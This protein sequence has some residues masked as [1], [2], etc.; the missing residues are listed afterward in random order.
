MGALA[1]LQLKKAYHKPED[2]IGKAFYLP[3]LA[4]ALNYDRAVGYFSSA[5][6]ALAWPSLR[7]FVDHGGKIRMI[8]SP[9]L[10]ANDANAMSE[11]Y[12]ARD[13]SVQGELLKSEIR[14]LLTT[15]GTLKPARVLA[16]LVALGVVD[17]QIAWVG[18][19]A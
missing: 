12:A 10:S 17:I 9:V 16:S 11:G 5:I 15:P 19:V 6:Y 18:D 1:E 7:E 14:R 4:R 13:D 8:C 3:C 2:D